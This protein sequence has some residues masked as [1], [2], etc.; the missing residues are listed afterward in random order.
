MTI[1]VAPPHTIYLYSFEH[2][3]RIV[4]LRISRV[5]LEPIP[6]ADRGDATPMTDREFLELTAKLAARFSTRDYTREEYVS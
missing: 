4:Y 1:P 3:D 5:S 2:Q 6:V